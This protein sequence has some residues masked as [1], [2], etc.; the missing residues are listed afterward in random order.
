MA[1]LPSFRKK[2][3]SAMSEQERPDE[4]WRRVKEGI[5]PS[6]VSRQRDGDTELETLARLS[7][8]VRDMLSAE[9]STQKGREFARAKLTVAIGLRASRANVSFFR[10]PAPR[11]AIATLF[12]AIAAVAYRQLSSPPLHMRELVRDHIEYL[13]LASPAQFESSDAGKVADWLKSQVGFAVAP[14]DLRS[15][16]ATLLGGRRCVIKRHL[17]AFMLYQR[18][19]ERLSLYEMNP[20]TT[21]LAGLSEVRSIAGRRVWLGSEL[22][23]NIA[24]WRDEDQLFVIVGSSPMNRLLRTVPRL[25]G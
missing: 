19:D 9:P 18:G 11:L 21:Q 2:V 15:H 22:G 4:L 12:L 7:V 1:T 25:H 24:A 10:R 23:F 17:I 14:V 6:A 3:V 20:T 5:Q 8:T 13:G 16:G